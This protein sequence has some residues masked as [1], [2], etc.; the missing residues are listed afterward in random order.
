MDDKKRKAIAG[1]DDF[2]ILSA[3]W[4]LACNDENPMITYEGITYRLGLPPEF[5]VKGL[6][7]GRGEMFRAKVPDRRLAAWKQQLRAGRHQPS[8][9]K[10]IGDPELRRQ[11]IDALTH[12]DAFRSQFR[13][14][15]GA[16]RSPIE[17]LEWGLEHIDRLRKAAAEDQEG[18]LK[19]WTTIRLP[20]LSLLVA[21]AAVAVSGLMQY[22]GLELQAQLKRLDIEAKPKQ[23]AYSSFM[24]LLRLTY[25]DALRGD[26]KEMSTKLSRLRSSYFTVE[27]FM[28]EKD[29]EGIWAQYLLFEDFCTVLA[30]GDG[31]GQHDFIEKEIKTERRYR[32]HEF[33]FRMTM[34]SALF[35]KS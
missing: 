9:L 20:L 2:D 33:A 28:N 27:P 18:R 14:E 10:D 25:E 8:W 32:A 1:A 23:E 6:V 5:D 19:R 21:L 22:R 3:I 31:T 16:Q 12:H 4:I 15:E 30:A 13:A 7:R 26:Q 24:G 17:V 35:G 34:Y 11:R 29:R